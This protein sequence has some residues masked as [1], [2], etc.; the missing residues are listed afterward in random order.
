MTIDERIKQLEEQTEQAETLLTEL[1][2]KTKNLLA[3]IE[4]R[5]EK[6]NKESVLAEYWNDINSEEKV[7]YLDS[8]NKIRHGYLIAEYSDNNANYSNYLTKEYAEQSQKIKEFND[9]LLAFKWCYDR[10]YTPDLNDYTQRKYYVF[11]NLKNNRYEVECCYIYAELRIYF[12][13]IEI[14]QKC[15]NWLNAE[16]EN[17][18]QKNTASH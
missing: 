15:C 5:Q 12:S 1:K 7:Y 11:F 9:K 14:A 4:E 6:K 8:Y 16:G 2:E 13:S 10:E 18:E 3:R 17:N